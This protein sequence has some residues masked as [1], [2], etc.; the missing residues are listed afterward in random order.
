MTAP[1][2]ESLLH[3][4]DQASDNMEMGVCN[5]SRSLVMGSRAPSFRGDLECSA[6]CE[7]TDCADASSADMAE[8]E[9]VRR[10]L[11]WAIALALGFMIVEVAGGLWANSL[12]ILT[13][14]AHLL[15][16]V[17]G[18]AISLFA[19]WMA[20]W[21]ATPKHTF[22]FHR[23]E[24]L[25]AL[26]SMQ[27]IWMITGILLYE[28]IQRLITESG[29]VDGRLMFFTA[30][31]GVGVNILMTMLLGH[32]HGHGHDNSHKGHGH[33]APSMAGANSAHAHAHS[34]AHGDHDH[35]HSAHSHGAHGHDNFLSPFVSFFT[36]L[37][38]KKGA[39]HAL[40]SQ[41][42]SQ[43]EQ[44]ALKA[45]SSSVDEEAI[46]DGLHK[47]A[48]AVPVDLRHSHHDHDHKDHDHDHLHG[49]SHDLRGSERPAEDSHFDGHRHGHGHG[50]AAKGKPCPA[51]GSGEE[52]AAVA[53][54]DGYAS[55]AAE[56]GESHAVNVNLQG[57]YLHV[58]GD[59]I[60]SVGVMLGGAIIWWK[61]EWKVVDLL[62]TLLFSVL[63]LFT[64]L[65][66]L[67]DIL[68]VLMESTPRAINATE[69]ENGIRELDGVTGVHELHIW[70]I[71]LG[72]VVLAVHVRI[73]STADPH[74]VLHTV[75][76]FC[77][78]EYGIS[79]ATVQV[80]RECD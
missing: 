30:A 44:R 56:G 29:E 20:S 1:M 9:E 69:L 63:V 42:L 70:A 40:L 21:R 77:S 13:D 58:L 43:E 75:L 19:I 38:G 6:T 65:K 54:P 33:S 46:G 78:N 76:E 15:S 10:K 16:D 36:K 80:E 51:A 74:D 11:V 73:A 49:A 79:H 28:A 2:E 4:Q 60:Q 48:T 62:C 64:T 52:G 14:A 17:A 32:H 41:T 67:R 3:H 5:S 71:T 57:A 50:E 8:R 31:S 45:R 24:I 34:H 47:S 26:V 12:A 53:A 72:K 22:G 37:L 39:Q 55:V 59:L 61:P 35:D 18:F 66:M 27:L 25:G 7:L 68:E 23:M